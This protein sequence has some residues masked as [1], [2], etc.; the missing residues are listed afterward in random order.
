MNHESWM[1]WMNN[2]SRISVG[3]GFNL[4]RPAPHQ[5]APAPPHPSP[6]LFVRHP[7]LRSAPAAA[8]AAHCSFEATT[9]GRQGCTALQGDP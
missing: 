7:A 3:W 9:S 5:S 8:P 2:E 4:K 6:L 1:G